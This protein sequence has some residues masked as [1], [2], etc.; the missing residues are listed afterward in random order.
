MHYQIIIIGA[1]PAGCSAA[2]RAA[3]AGLSVMIIEARPFPR[4]RPGET[5]HPGIEPLFHELGVLPDISDRHYKRPV[6]FFCYENEKTS[7]V[8]YREDEKKHPWHGWLI[9]RNEMDDCLL[10]RALMMNTRLLNSRGGIKMSSGFPTQVQVGNELFICDYV[11]DATGHNFWLT[12]QLGLPL[13]KMSGNLTCWYGNCEGEFKQAGEAPCFFRDKDCW[14]WIA[15]INPS[16]IQWTHLDYRNPI[17]EK[18]WRPVILQSIRPI[19]VTMSRDVTWR[20]STAPSGKNYFCLGDAAFVTDPSS[21]KGVLKAVM[22]GMMA[23]HL[24]ENILLKKNIEPVTASD[25]YNGWIDNWF[26]HEMKQ[27][28]KA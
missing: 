27:L 18:T 17:K 14:T 19:N 15:Q 6:G 12:R 10:S 28:E 23:A 25:Y 1:G 9:P 8:P 4:S 21:S 16:R 7:F 20:V 3:E 26:K 2:I 5:L 11:L 22:S 24:I 13:K